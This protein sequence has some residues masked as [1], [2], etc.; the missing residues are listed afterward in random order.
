[1][2]FPYVKY[3]GIVRPVIPIKLKNQNQE[4]G[5]DVL[6]DSGADICLFDAEI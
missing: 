2:K 3:N 1:M 6:V 4:I 5:Y